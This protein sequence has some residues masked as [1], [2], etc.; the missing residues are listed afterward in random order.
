[1]SYSDFR[2]GNECPRGRPVPVAAESFSLF[3][4]RKSMP[5][6]TNGTFS[7]KFPEPIDFDFCGLHSRSTISLI[8]S[9]QGNRQP[10]AKHSFAFGGF[11][12]FPSEEC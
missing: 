9:E 10:R 5:E 12:G 8:D 6:S 3:P 7:G 4:R 2:R 1:M 11:Y